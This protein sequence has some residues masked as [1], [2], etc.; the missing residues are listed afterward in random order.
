MLIPRSRLLPLP[1]QKIILSFSRDAWDPTSVTM[2]GRTLEEF[3]LIMK[4]LGLRRFRKS[5]QIVRIL[6]RGIEK[7]ALACTDAASRLRSH[8]KYLSSRILVDC[9]AV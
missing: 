7:S 8:L 9:Q 5:S 1:Q 6:N 3:L 2:S 4:I